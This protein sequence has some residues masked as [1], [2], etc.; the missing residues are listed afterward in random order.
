MTDHLQEVYAYLNDLEEGDEVGTTIDL[1]RGTPK[2]LAEM[3]PRF[4]E[5]MG[6][7][8]RGRYRKL[9]RTAV[10]TPNLTD[11]RW[12][13]THIFNIKFMREG[14]NR[15]LYTKCRAGRLEAKL[16]RMAAGDVRIISVSESWMTPWSPAN[17]HLRE[18]GIPKYA[19]PE[20]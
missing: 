10:K 11:L 14:R 3:L 5:Q 2:A 18:L 20:R 16:L 6:L 8:R 7:A 19:E 12:A 4:L 9:Y 15:V 1:R 13:P 17:Y